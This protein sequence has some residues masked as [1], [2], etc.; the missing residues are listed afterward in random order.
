MNINAKPFFIT[1]K[2]YS[3]TNVLLH[4]IQLVCL[5]L[6]SVPHLVHIIVFVLEI[7]LF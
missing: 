6:F 2:I 7:F 5:L 3:N 1:I 4:L